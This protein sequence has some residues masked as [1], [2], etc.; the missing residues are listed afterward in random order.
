MASQK[1]SFSDEYKK[2]AKGETLSKGNQL[3]TLTPQMDKFG[4]MRI[5]GRLGNTNLAAHVKYPIIL[6]RKSTLAKRVADESHR[7]MCHGGVQM[8]TQ[9]LRNKY[10]IL[11]IRILMRHVVYYCKVCALHRQTVSRQFMADLPAV[12][13]QP[14]PAFENTG[15][16]YAGPIKLKV[17]RNVTTK[18][19]IAVFVCMVYKTVPL[20]LVSDGTSEA[21]IAA[22]TRFVNIRA[23]RV[24]HMHSDNAKTFV[25]AEA[26]LKRAAEVWHSH[27]VM[28][29]LEDCSIQWHYIVPRAPHHGGIW[30]A[31]D[32]HL[33]TRRSI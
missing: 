10:W 32:K 4:V 15:V 8:C 26:E 33:Q 12:R 29:Y 28:K 3:W 18:G 9:F 17:S 20:E 27:D 16:D 21:F 25:G 5:C 11:G 1:A 19:Y 22:L 23:G 31:A 30:E 24:K 14:A 2:I 6:H 7:I 13:L